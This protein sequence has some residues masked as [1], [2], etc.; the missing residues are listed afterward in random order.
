M[1]ATGL[2]S[3]DG[4]AYDGPG[5][6][7][8]AG[9]LG[10]AVAYD[11]IYETHTWP[12]IAVNKLTGL[13]VF[14][15]GKTYQRGRAGRVDARTTPFGRLMARPSQTINPLAFW[16]WFIAMHHIHGKAFAV[17]GRPSSTGAPV[18]LHLVHPT[19]MR[20]GPAGGEWVNPGVAGAETADFRWWWKRFNDQP[21][22]PIDRRDFLFW[23]RFSPS[24]P[25]CG[26]S[27]MEPLRSTLEAEANAIAAMSSTFRRGGQHNLVLTHP[28][29][30]GANPMATKRLADQY[31]L[32]HGGV[33]NW[34]RP[35]VL[36][37]GMSAVPITMSN[38]DM[39]YIDVRKLD[40]EEVA[41]EFDLPPPSIHIL[42]RATFSNVVEQNRSLYV[43]TMPRHLSGF[44]AMVDFDLRDGSFGDGRPDFPDDT[45]FEYLV[46]GVLRGSFEERMSAY[47]TMIQNGIATPAEIRERE[48]LPFVAGSDVLYINGAV[49]PIQEAGA[50]GGQAALAS[51]RDRS[52][53]L[54][55]LSRP[56]SLDEIDPDRLVDGLEPDAAAAVRGALDVARFGRL[57]VAEFR[58][59]IK[60]MGV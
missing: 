27:P 34:G 4:F 2:T 5:R 16:G 47:A 50:G 53:V 59:M 14:L 46:D 25:N 60:A 9:S 57:S 28:G 21:E 56:V 51:A 6:H 13:Q 49:V 44:E 23:P 39:Q 37:E 15:P 43:Q 11:R 55:R 20:Y 42:D 24:G 7:P 10:G 36:E 54:G 18:E 30:F 12:N 38:K 22:R 29:T 19:R 33:Q 41:A 32:R 58:Q 40:R 45:Y 3:A 35:L 48:N 31:E 52:T 1:M 17:K 8:L 26:L